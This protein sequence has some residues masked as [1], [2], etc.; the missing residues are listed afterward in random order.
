MIRANEHRETYV[1]QAHP[2]SIDAIGYLL[3][4]DRCHALARRIGPEG[5]PG[6]YATRVEV[7]LTSECN[8]HCS[9]CRSINHETPV[10]DREY[11]FAEL[12][13]WACSGTRHIQWTGGEPTLHHNLLELVRHAK[14]LGMSNS[15]STNGSAR[16]EMYFE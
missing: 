16:P 2:S 4:D 7:F 14:N 5:Q 8:F 10:W 11:L 13:R 3:G 15:M 12:E 1:W 6:H 9:Y